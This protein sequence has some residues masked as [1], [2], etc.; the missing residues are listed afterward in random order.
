MTVAPDRTAV[1]SRRGRDLVAPELFERMTDFCAEE[2]GYERSLAERIMSEALAFVDVMGV[3]GEAMSPSRVVDPGWHTFM[4]HTEEYAEF[5]L[6]RYDRFIHHAPK[7]RYRD[8]ATMADVVSR[9][10]AH[11]YEVDESLWGAKAE[12][13]EPA[14]CGD[15]PCC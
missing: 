14:C 7:S 3:T 1:A 10:R 13:N 9:I 5:C 4:L 2:Y 15:G 11:G 6:T 12:C 8:R